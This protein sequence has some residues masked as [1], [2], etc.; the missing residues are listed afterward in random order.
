[1]DDAVSRLWHNESKTGLLQTGKA[2]PKIPCQ[3]DINSAMDDFFLKSKES[4][5]TKPSRIS[6]LTL[7]THETIKVMSF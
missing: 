3:T 1:M 5:G 4:R 6:W 2:L 7:E